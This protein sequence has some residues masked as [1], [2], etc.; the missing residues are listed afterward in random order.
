MEEHLAGMAKS[1]RVQLCC[2]S[3]LQKSG[4]QINLP[5]FLV[6]TVYYTQDT[7][8]DIRMRRKFAVNSCHNIEVIV[9]KVM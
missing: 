8:I 2:W 6:K 1:L 9:I 4:I 7:C 5:S 3:G